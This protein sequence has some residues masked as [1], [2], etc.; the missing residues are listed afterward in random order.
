MFRNQHMALVPYNPGNNRRTARNPPRR[1]G[2]VPAQV[3]DYVKNQ[4]KV[5]LEPVFYDKQG[6]FPIPPTSQPSVMNLIPSANREGERVNMDHVRFSFTIYDGSAIAT[7]TS[8]VRV[9]VFE[10]K[11]LRLPTTNDILEST[12]ITQ[13]IQSPHRFTMRQFYRVLYDQKFQVA[14]GSAP[15]ATVVKEFK[16]KGQAKRFDDGAVPPETLGLLYYLVVGEDATLNQP[17]W[18]YSI[19]TVYTDA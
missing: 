13:I 1:E 18:N 12:A 19:R 16:L 6:S 3:K 8:T 17:L 2:K 10:W 9:L 15:G 11:A 5:A 4:L 14:Q 7:Y